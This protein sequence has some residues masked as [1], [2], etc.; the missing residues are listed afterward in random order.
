MAAD[1]EQDLGTR[2]LEEVFRDWALRY[3]H[4]ALVNR[5][6]FVGAVLSLLQSGILS[7]QRAV[8]LF[9]RVVSFEAK[10]SVEVPR[11]QHQ[12]F[13]L[14]KREVDLNGAWV[15]CRARSKI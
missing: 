11:R 5:F 3:L 6:F 15:E 1:L 9:R 7:H 2:L 10:C 13:G 4:P 8:A 12:R 14:Q